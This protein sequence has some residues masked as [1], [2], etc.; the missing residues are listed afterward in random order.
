MSL[1]AWYPLN[2]NLKNNCVGPNLTTNYMYGDVNK[3][4]LVNDKDIDEL[5]N[6]LSDTNT[7]SISK[8]LGD[9]N[10][11]GKTN[12]KDYNILSKYL[13]NDRQI[14]INN[15]IRQA[16]NI[17]RKEP[18]WVD[19]KTGKAYSNI[20]EISAWANID[21]IKGTKIL[22]ISFWFKADKISQFE[23]ILGFETYKTTDKSYGYLRAE[24]N[25]AG[26]NKLIHWFNNKHLSND[27][28]LL[29]D[30]SPDD[31]A[32]GKWVHVT[33]IFEEDKATMYINGK[34]TYS[35]TYPNSHDNIEFTGYF[36]ISNDK[37]DNH[38]GASGD[39]RVC[40]VKIYNHV[41]SKKEILEDYKQ[42][43]LH[44]TFENPYVT[45]TI[46][47]SH[48]VIV[49]DNH[50]GKVTLGSD[51]T[52]KYMNR[53]DMTLWSGIGIDVGSLLIKPGRY[54]TWSMEVM[55]IKDIE[56][57]I[58]GNGECSNSSH[59]S[60]N[61][62]HFDIIR[63]YSH[64][65]HKLDGS[66]TLPKGKLEAYKW[67]R[68][69]FTVKVKQDCTN[70]NLF[71]MFVPYIPSGDSSVKVYYRNS[72]LEER[73]YDS[74]YVLSGRNPLTIKD[75][76][77]MGN[78][79]T[80]VYQRIEIPIVK[81]GLSANTS[82]GSI[83]Y[84]ST[85][86][87]YTITGFN[88][89]NNQCFCLGKIKYNSSYHYIS[90][91]CSY[92]FDITLKDLVM[93]SGKTLSDG[94]IDSQIQGLTHFKD[95]TSSWIG[96][97]TSVMS[98]SKRL[99][100]GKISNATFH[101]CT[102]KQVTAKEAVTNV[103]YYD[104]GL[105]LNYIKSGTIIISNLHAYYDNLDTS[106]LTITDKSVIGSHSLYLN[107]KN[108]I[109]CG[110]V[111]PSLM[112][113]LTASIWLYRDDWTTK[114]MLPLYSSFFG[115]RDNGGF[116]IGPSRNIANLHFEV[117]YNSVG[118]LYPNDIDMTKLSAGWHLITGVADK[119]RV[120]LYLDGKLYNENI[121][122]KNAQINMLPNNNST[123]ARMPIYVGA[124]LD[125]WGV[126]P[127]LRTVK[128][129]YM[130]D[131]RL[132]A[133]A[134]NDKDIK[135]LYNVRARID[136]KSNLYCNQLVETKSENLVDYSVIEPGTY[137]GVTWSAN[138]NKQNDEFTMTIAGN[139]ATT[140]GQQGPYF[141][142]YEK[143]GPNHRPIANEKYRLEMWFKL[144]KSGN[145]LIGSE[146]LPIKI[147]TYE[148]GKWYYIEQEGN[149]SDSVNA[150]IFYFYTAILEANDKIIIKDL[151]F[152]RLYDT[153]NQTQE[154]TKKGQFKTFQ[155]DET[156]TDKLISYKTIN[157]YNA[158]WLQV[159]HHNTNNNTVWFKD[160]SEAL[161]C[162]S[163][164]K[165]SILDQLEGFR[166]SDS[167]FEFLLEYP[168]D[169]PNQYNRWKQTDNPATTLEAN[170]STYGTPANGYE[171]IH[172]DWTSKGWG[173]LLKSKN[174]NNAART[175]IDGSTN[176]AN[177]Y[178]SIGCYNNHA[179]DWKDKMLGPDGST[180]MKEVNLYVRLDE[181]Y[182]GATIV[183]K[184]GAE[185][186]EVFYHDNNNCKIFF[187]NQTEALHTNS[188][189][190][191]SILDQLEKF[192]G[193]DGKFEFLLEYPTD[194]PGKYNRWKQT[195]NPVKVTVN[196]T[197]ASGYEAIHVD[198]PDNNWGGLLRDTSSNYTL[199]K[200]S[201]VNT[202]NWFFAIGAIKAWG[203]SYKG[204]PG[205]Y[206]GASGYS[207]PNGIVHDIHLYVRI[208]NLEDNDN[209]KIYNRKTK[210]N[211]IIEI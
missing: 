142:G 166:G 210:T 198:W 177:W 7:D 50:S 39:F 141:R 123:I 49:H 117:Y 29:I 168:Q 182:M 9:V 45:E 188:Q 32:L 130:D 70:P 84:D 13:N 160:E 171:V 148:A 79:G 68:I 88:S 199:L 165:F 52:G 164:Y 14:D 54:Y 114:P 173:G 176:H 55:P 92:E 103:D 106:K 96:S 113:E 135:A 15:R 48:K 191:F 118:Y 181:K 51:S 150:I 209:F 112:D 42:P 119:N 31:A 107:G 71:H 37:H 125:G 121:H 157:K 53:T 196:N 152:Y 17:V 155:I 73:M 172:V 6:V 105:R 186:L 139:T 151:R 77:G 132:Y 8:I 149:A 195:D 161:N 202:D 90:S 46:N 185:W 116:A 61:D 140:A 86:N 24:T 100:N 190:K 12:V 19:G 109:N 211:E 78:N 110:V 75:N 197:Y 34:Q 41:L 111:T 180:G 124:E 44:Y 3:D 35:R 97:P 22:S 143:Y 25:Y 4:G 167:K 10:G 178:Y 72:Q 67:T 170:N 65:N 174:V 23:D 207:N 99:G 36:Y 120:A 1:I 204:V 20:T 102:E 153:E 87:T 47:I 192:R 134:L 145:W 131:V 91:V 193:N 144:P 80:Q 146:V 62:I 101:I 56:Y 69:Y 158:T 206:P 26:S 38:S 189:Y 127:V 159:F 2:G 147:K 187:N 63:G 85:N 76:S 169:L 133:T 163:R 194:I 30:N 138:Y 82:Q 27:D 28:G 162:D 18:I 98:L 83:K 203:S 115:V 179:T 94:E 93:V 128:D 126:S 11:D 5:Y 137:G 136:N 33:S 108:Y 57:V 89:A 40:N 156:S 104:F 60:S 66:D 43:I 21:K 122:N 208:D 201:I 16:S 129:Y 154:I 58:D 81:S 175:L 64:L 184:Y 183:D 95:G 200:G 205:P 59:A 74:P